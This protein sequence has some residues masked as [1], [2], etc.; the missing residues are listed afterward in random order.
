MTIVHPT[1]FSPEAAAAEQEA[2]RLVRRL[3]AELVLVH[4]TTEA[5]LY[6]EHVFSMPD[7]KRIFETQA[8]W[9]DDRLAERAEALSR[10][11][12]QTRW[13]H[14]TGVVHDEIVRAAREASAD[15][16]VIGTHG[17][18]GLDRMMLGS[19]ADRVVRMSPC[20]VVTV[21]PR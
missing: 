16:I 2:I 20:P 5:P 19:V 3:G 8:K 10:D 21:R 18:G 1:D 14:R 17:R 7:V 15:Y 11:G 12:V 9:A 6:G 13:Q 4:V